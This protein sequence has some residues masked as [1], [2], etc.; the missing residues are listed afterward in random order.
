M[1]WPV[2]LLLPG[3]VPGTAVLRLKSISRPGVAA[4]RPPPRQFPSSRSH[5]KSV[6]LGVDVRCGRRSGPSI[7]TSLRP[8]LNLSSRDN[9]RRNLSGQQAWGPADLSVCGRPPFKAAVL[10]ASYSEKTAIS[11]AGQQRPRLPRRAVRTSLQACLGSR[12]TF[13]DRLL[14]VWAGE[15]PAGDPGA[16]WEGQGGVRQ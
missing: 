2:D 9:D 10:A 3:V 8:G 16:V 7:L 11:G 6:K 15:S 4:D 12:P 1:L 5:E 13:P 14:G